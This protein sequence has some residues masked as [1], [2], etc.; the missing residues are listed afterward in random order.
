MIL[1]NCA[2]AGVLNRAAAIA[3]AHSRNT[4]MK[5]IIP[6]LGNGSRCYDAVR[7]FGVR[8]VSPQS[9]FVKHEDFAG[10]WI[11]QNP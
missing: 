9:S 1:I 11:R 6:S 3:T 2:V 7:D 10:S 5:D 8:I 4:R